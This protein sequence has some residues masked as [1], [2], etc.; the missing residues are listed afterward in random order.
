MTVAN[1]GLH[2][3][4]A[5]R[6]VGELAA[7]CPRESVPSQDDGTALIE[8]DEVEDV[9]ADADAE[10]GDGSVDGPCM[11]AL[12][13]DA[14]PSSTRVL[15]GA[16]HRPTRRPPAWSTILPCKVPT[17]LRPLLFGLLRIPLLGDAE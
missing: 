9:L 16:P 15:R 3:D 17:D 6:H 5:G 7:S 8:A 11:A 4:Q 1:A 2:D 12:L 13:T 10:D 14:Y